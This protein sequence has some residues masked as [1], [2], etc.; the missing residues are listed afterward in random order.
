MYEYDTVLDGCVTK[1]EQNMCNASVLAS[2]PLQEMVVPLALLTYSADCSALEVDW[3]KPEIVGNA[4]KKSFVLVLR[5]M[6]TSWPSRHA[7]TG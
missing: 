3:Q 4:L 5:A 7:S 6:R 2:A 1:S